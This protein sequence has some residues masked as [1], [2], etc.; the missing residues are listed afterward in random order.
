LRH[1]GTS[2]LF[3]TGLPIHHVQMVTQHGSWKI[4]E[5]YTHL[6]TLDT[7]N[8]YEGW[9]PLKKATTSYVSLVA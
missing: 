1:E 4:L 9:E 6:V 7:F 8:K 2:W 3:E 5:R